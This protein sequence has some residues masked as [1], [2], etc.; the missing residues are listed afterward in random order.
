[1][2][3]SSPVGEWDSV[4]PNDHFVQFYETDACLMDAV[5]GFIGAGIQRGDGAVVVGTPEHRDDLDSRLRAAGVDVAGA[6][7]E[8]RLVELDAAETLGRFMVDGRPDYE[9]FKAV[10]EPAI[11]RAGAGGRTVRAFGEMVAILWKDGHRGAAVELEEHWNTLGK[12][13]AFCLFCAYPLQDCSLHEHTEHFGQVCRSHSRVIPGES[14]TRA[15]SVD[16]QARLVAELQQQAAA[17]R[18]EIAA[19]REAE[20]ELRM[21]EREL[22]DFI[23]N[24]NEGLHRVGP[25]GTILWANRAE[26]EML[27]YERGEYIGRSISEFHADKDV[28]RDIMAR[29]AAGESLHNRAARLRCKDGT[30][31]HVLMNSTTFRENGEFVYTRCFTRDVTEEVE[32]R[33]A[34]VEAQ[35]R[36]RMILDLLPAAVYACDRDGR[37]TYFNNMA[38]KMWG[39]RPPLNSDAAKFCACYRVYHRGEFLPPDKTPMAVAVREGASFRNLEPVFER[40]DGTRIHACV[41]IDPLF[42]REGKAAGAVNVFQDIGTLVEAR[43]AL[44]AHRDLL[45]K[46]VAERTRELEET[47]ERLRLSERMAALGTLSTGLGHDIGNLLLPI[48]ACVDSLRQSGLPGHLLKDVEGIASAT[49]YLRQLSAG[50]RMLAQDPAREQRRESLLLSA[51]WEEARPILRASLPAG[52]ALEGMFDDG[53]AVAMGRPAL[54]Q[55][56]FNLVQNAGDALRP[57]GYGTVRVSGVRRGEWVDLTVRDDGPGMSDEVR[58][59]CTDPFFTTKARALST[60]LGLSLVC[61]LTRE[62]GGTVSVRSEPGVGSEFTLTVPSGEPREHAP[63]RVYVAA[64]EP[65]RRAVLRAEVEAQSGVLVEIA[66]EAEVAVVED[67][68]HAA[69]LARRCGRVLLLTDEEAPSGGPVRIVLRGTPA[70]QRAALVEAMHEVRLK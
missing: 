23:E 32:A 34:A 40:P 43:E 39:Y 4:K 2:V 37:I 3:V 60:G 14:F 9:R 24:A 44:A 31:R 65:R 48:A 66:E 12:A 18:S 62:A 46:A 10:I 58:R 64:R 59:R 25:D 50:L 30:I 36:L 69:G 49:D 70:E 42:D 7:A 19:R 20:R 11:R 67:P 17:L 13:H 22:S 35:E 52:V 53:A 68:R 51:W 33:A 26:L 5:S 57:R 38:E 56:V 28:C 55:A 15:K 41:N 61:G 6:R 47:H 21:R 16:E 54:A 8:G 29:L 27:G 45:E 63:V 1:M